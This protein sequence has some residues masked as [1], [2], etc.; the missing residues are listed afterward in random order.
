MLNYFPVKSTLN[1]SNSKF[2]PFVIPLAF[3]SRRRHP[4]RVRRVSTL[5]GAH[6]NALREQEHT[7]DN[8]QAWCARGSNIAVLSK[9]VSCNATRDRA[10][11]L[12]FKSSRPL[13]RMISD[14][15]EVEKQR[16][17]ETTR[18]AQAGFEPSTLKSVHKLSFF[19]LAR[20]I[21]HF[22]CDENGKKKVSPKFLATFS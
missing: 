8:Q 22:E 5:C 4:R 16:G 14:S 12:F 11:F 20:L 2:A 6:D 19:P 15:L 1:N 17:T 10:R 21:S 18:G 7:R 9:R 3:Q 13:A